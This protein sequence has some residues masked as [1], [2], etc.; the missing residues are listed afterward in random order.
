M[1]ES[2]R[3]LVFANEDLRMGELAMSEAIY[4]QVCFHAQ[5]CAEK[6]VKALL[7]HQGHPPPR[8]HRL[9]DLLSLLDPNPLGDLTFELQLLDRFYIPTRYPDALPG[10]L[11]EGLPDRQDAQQALDL[12]RQI[13]ELAK[14]ILHKSPGREE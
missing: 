4:N 13:L 8:T 11:P 10:A 12:A 7:A 6:A 2:E 1:S 3:W 9:G 14:A 5:Q